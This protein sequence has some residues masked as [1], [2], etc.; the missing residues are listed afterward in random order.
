MSENIKKENKNVT[1]FIYDKINLKDLEF[2]F[3]GNSKITAT[4]G[5]FINPR[6]NAFGLPRIISCPGA[7]ETC[8]RA[9]YTQGIENNARDLYKKYKQNFINLNKILNN[10]EEYD[11]NELVDIFSAWISKNCKEFRWHVSGDV[12]NFRYAEFIRYI[13]LN[14]PGV[15][16]WLYTR[17]FNLEILS[18]LVTLDN[19]VVNIS[20]DADN[21]SVAS[22][23]AKRHKLRLCYFTIDGK[24]P[25]DLKPGSVIFPDYNLRG[26]DLEIPENH[27]WWT[28]LTEKEKSMVCEVD[29]F[30][31]SEFRRCGVGCRKCLNFCL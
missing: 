1:N 20:A 3:D 13:C 7:T 12:F 27:I 16:F 29:F 9:C 25:E 4:N 10:P 31:Q 22:E 6:P 17:N 24:I 30:G 8:K 2:I 26:R 21:Y 18:L 19:L 23:I 28:S 11:L 5:T 14:S 15:R